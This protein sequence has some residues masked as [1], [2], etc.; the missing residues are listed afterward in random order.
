[1]SAPG[2]DQL[3]I[4]QEFDTTLDQLHHRH[5][6]HPLR[7]TLAES[8]SN[9]QAHEATLEMIG[10]EQ[11]EAER[12]RKRIDDEVA[13]VQARRNDI[14]TKLYDG[15]VTATKDLL[16]LQEES[17]HLA[18]RQHDMEDDELEVMEQLEAIEARAAEARADLER[19][20]QAVTANHAELEVAL[21]E[22]D[23]QIQ[24]TSA[25]RASA[26]VSIPA[27]LLARY[28]A[29]R[30]DMGGIA[31]AQL[32]NN[33]CSGCH[34]SISAVEADRMKN[35]PD[36]EVINCDSCGRLLIR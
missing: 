12:Q 15:S 1:M 18:Q 21:A 26:V 13:T 22:V 31:V 35:L 32:I 5:A 19:A 10:A 6:N 17:G 14:E 8:E 3:L 2:Y 29:L 16:A 20:E 11:L 34:L 23:D 7:A 30:S 25:E 36:D 27:E 28:E 9:R 24:A 33:S 4:V